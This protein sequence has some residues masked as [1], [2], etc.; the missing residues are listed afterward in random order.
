MSIKSIVQ[1]TSC[2]KLD[3]GYRYPA[4]SWVCHFRGERLERVPKATWQKACE[5]VGSKGKCFTIC[6]ERRCG[7][8]FGVESVSESPWLYQV[9]GRDRFLTGTILSL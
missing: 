8:W 4:C 6:A 7:I 3:L 1:M 5:Q 2:S 9:I